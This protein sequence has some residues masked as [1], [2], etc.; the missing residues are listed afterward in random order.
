MG[1]LV[2]SEEAI[3]LET[4]DRVGAVDGDVDI[5]EGMRYGL[6]SLLDN[7]PYQGEEIFHVMAFLSGMYGFHI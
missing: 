5:A 3:F 7:A 6:I 2:L 1:S 4:S